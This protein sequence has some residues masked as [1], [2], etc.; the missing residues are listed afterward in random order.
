MDTINWF[1]YKF[2]RRFIEIWNTMVESFNTLS[3]DEKIILFTS[4]LLLILLLNSIFVL[5]LRVNF[6]RRVKKLGFVN[7]SHINTV[8]E[9]YDKNIFTRIILFFW[10]FKKLVIVEAKSLQI[11]LEETPVLVTEIMDETESTSDLEDELAEETHEED[12]LQSSI[13]IEVEDYIDKR[14]SE[15]EKDLKKSLNSTLINLMSEYNTKKPKTNEE[16]P[17]LEVTK[18][19]E[20]PIDIIVEDPVNI[21]VES[22]TPQEKTLEVPEIVESESEIKLEETPVLE[23]E[24]DPVIEKEIVKQYIVSKH[25]ISGWQIKKEGSKRAHRLFNSKK[26]AVAFAIKTKLDYEIK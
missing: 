3:R 23:K 12:P 5:V 7:V 13:S 15:L 25:S 10:N 9:V 4:L 1:F 11:P 2:S 26:Q 18:V 6:N 8:N 20:E 24:I 16:T 21:V 22:S 17:V 19:I 14:F